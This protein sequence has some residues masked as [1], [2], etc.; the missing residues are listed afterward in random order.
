LKKAYPPI[1]AE[2]LSVRNWL[3]SCNKNISAASDALR[4]RAQYHPQ[5]ASRARTDF[6]GLDPCRR[7]YLG[8]R[9]KGLNLLKIRGRKLL[10][11]PLC[12]SWHTQMLAI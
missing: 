8:T 12:A 4:L 1:D 11:D 2:V 9:W 3:Y 6:Y 5:H 7:R 10:S